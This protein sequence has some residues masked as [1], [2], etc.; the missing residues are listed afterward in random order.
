MS[1]PVESVHTARLTVPVSGNPA[2]TVDVVEDNE[3]H[4][5]TFIAT[6]GS[7]AEA[8]QKIK[9]FLDDARTAAQD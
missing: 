7:P 5:I 9:S 2:E 4:T 1:I 8:R 3:L 6:G